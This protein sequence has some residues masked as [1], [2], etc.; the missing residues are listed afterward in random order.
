MFSLNFMFLCLL[1]NKL[2]TKEENNKTGCNFNFGHQCKKAKRWK[3]DR[4]EPIYKTFYES[5]IK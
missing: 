3:S 1:I 2:Y 4:N 5:L